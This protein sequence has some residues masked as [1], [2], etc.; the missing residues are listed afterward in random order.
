MRADATD[1]RGRLRKLLVARAVHGAATR[2]ARDV[3]AQVA[4]RRLERRLIADGRVQLQVSP[5]LGGDARSS[6]S[7]KHD[8]GDAGRTQ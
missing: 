8:C 5:A 6:A 1:V 3:Q 2:E 7:A 4:G